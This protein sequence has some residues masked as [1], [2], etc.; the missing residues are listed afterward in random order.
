MRLRKRSGFWHRVT[1]EA[2]ADEIRFIVRLLAMVCLFEEK[3]CPLH[4]LALAP[5]SPSG[6]EL[7]PLPITYRPGDR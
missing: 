4:K 7:V 2:L 3:S 5:T 1:P 6:Y